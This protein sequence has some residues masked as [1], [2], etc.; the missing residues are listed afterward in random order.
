MTTAQKE[1]SPKEAIILL[2]PHKLQSM[3][4][5]RA[6]LSEFCKDN[7][8]TIIDI[9][10]LCDEY[11]YLAMRRLSQLIR[12]S[13]KS[14]SIITNRSILAA[15]PSLTLWSAL[16]AINS[17]KPIDLTRNF[18]RELKE[19]TAKEDSQNPEDFRLLNHKEVERMSD[20][21]TDMHYA[22]MRDSSCRGVQSQTS[23][24]F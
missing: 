11:D 14:I 8:I 18:L 21:L 24:S 17:S 4:E 13:S 23:S 7:D 12:Y 15:I 9:I 2:Y 22:I 16:E 19:S 10:N 3:K 20:W 6:C 1:T 5:L